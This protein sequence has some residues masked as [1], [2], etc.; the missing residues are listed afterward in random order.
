MYI[1]VNVSHSHVSVCFTPSSETR[2]ALPEDGAYHT[3]TCKRNVVN[4]L[5][6]TN[7][8]VQ[9]VGIFEEN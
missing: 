1:T 2:V 5:L 3:E 6:Y 7:I 4:I 9:L 8:C